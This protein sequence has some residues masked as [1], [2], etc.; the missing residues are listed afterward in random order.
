MDDSTFTNTEFVPF[1][2]ENGKANKTFRLKKCMRNIYK[3]QK[4]EGNY[5]K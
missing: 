4:A 2:S 3:K 1:K 5:R